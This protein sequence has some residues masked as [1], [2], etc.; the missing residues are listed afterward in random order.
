[1]TTEPKEGLVAKCTVGSFVT[2][3]QG[4]KTGETGRAELFI[5]AMRYRCRALTTGAPSVRKT[6]PD[7]PDSADK[8]DNL[9]GTKSYDDPTVK[10]LDGFFI[11]GIQGFGT[12]QSK[13]YGFLGELRYS[14]SSQVW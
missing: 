10:C 9:S 1:V 8:F 3:I 11:S 6:D 14:C 13:K 7:V 4:F 2:A 12:Q 5:A